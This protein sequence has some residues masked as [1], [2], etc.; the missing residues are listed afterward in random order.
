MTDT[1]GEP[2]VAGQVST[3][4][5]QLWSKHYG[6]LVRLAALMTD[7]VP[8]AEEIVQD[9]F[10]EL[11]QRRQDITP[12][13]ERAYLRR[14]VANRS[15]SL[16][17]RRRVQ[18]RH[19]DAPPGV[20]PPADHRVLQAAGHDLLL[21]AIASLPMRQ[22]QVIVLRYYAEAPIAETAAALGI[23]QAAVTTSA[24]RALTTLALS[25]ETLR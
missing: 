23:S 7:S 25:K 15:R 24:H 22:R 12:G 11:W 14:S 19:P 5:E 13:K 4:P 18:R 17:R 21:A 3:S 10:T 16:L 8:L 1:L 9:A 2:A 6:Q 20:A